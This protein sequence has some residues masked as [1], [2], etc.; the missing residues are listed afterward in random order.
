MLYNCIRVFI[1]CIKNV[2]KIKNRKS[3]KEILNL[4]V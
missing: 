3:I 1:F 4:G 2:L